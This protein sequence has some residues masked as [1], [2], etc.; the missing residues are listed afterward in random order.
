VAVRHRDARWGEVPIALV[1]LKPGATLDAQ[2]LLQWCRSQLASYKLPKE[3]RFVALEDFPR[4]ST[5]KIQRHEIEKR[6]DLAKG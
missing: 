5:G 6:L 2:A 1:A 4:S 3:I